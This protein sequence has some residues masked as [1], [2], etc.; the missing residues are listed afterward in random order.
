[1]EQDIS[2]ICITN[3]EGD[4]VRAN[5]NFTLLF[6][7]EKQEIIGENISKIIPEK[8]KERHNNS[9]NS[10]KKTSDSKFTGR[11]EVELEGLKKNGE[12]KK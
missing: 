6:N 1:M 4:I 3:K 11:D 5:S 9:A 2:C 12:L 8:F 10:D 7:Y